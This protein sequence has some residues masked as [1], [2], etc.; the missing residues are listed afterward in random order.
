M[1]F[2]TYLLDQALD[3]RRQKLEEARQQTLQQTFDLLDKVATP[4]GV[5]HA[6]V[7]GSLLR[8]ER[9]HERSDIDVASGG[10]W[11]GGIFYANE[12]AVGGAGARNV[13]VVDLR[14]CHFAERV[15]E[16]GML[17]TPSKI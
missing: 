13:D 10:D 5:E 17:W 4:L 3:Q 14:K 11:A 1:A 16:T 12:S 2:D 8:E 9:F 15:R 6:Y 7:F